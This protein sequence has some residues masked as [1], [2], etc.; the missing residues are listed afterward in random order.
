MTVPWH[1]PPTYK[2]LHMHTGHDQRSLLSDMSCIMS[3]LSPAML[4]MEF[5]ARG[6]SESKPH[7]YSDE[8]G[9]CCWIC[10][11]EFQSSPFEASISDW[12]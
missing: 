12:T 4:S 1:I 10:F 6:H 9:K 3:E 7:R 11:T 2:L 5:Y 8:I